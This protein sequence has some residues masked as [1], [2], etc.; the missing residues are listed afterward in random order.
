MVCRTKGSIFA[1]DC[2]GKM[3]TRTGDEPLPC[4]WYWHWKKPARAENAKFTPRFYPSDSLHAL[5]STYAGL[6]NVLEA[7]NGDA[8]ENMWLRREVLPGFLTPIRSS[9][10]YAK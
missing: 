7:D 10:V 5:Y 9:L 3:E 2:V 6:Q 1:A 4:A 8:A